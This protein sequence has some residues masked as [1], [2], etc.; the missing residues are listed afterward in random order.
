MNAFKLPAPQRLEAWGNFR[1]SL[2]AMP[3][4]DQI[5]AVAEF[6]QH[7]P[8]DRW[9]L[10]P[11]SPNDWMSPWEMLYEGQYCINCVAVGIEST[12]RYSG[13][14]ESRL[15]LVM[16]KEDDALAS[17]FFVVKIDNKYVLNYSYGQ[18][19]PIEELDASINF[20]YAYRWNG[21]S[22]ARI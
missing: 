18:C 19:V 2:S 4:L 21:K 20:L 5:M 17:E 10:D 16:I 6:W 7:C 8:F 1:D 9:V 22:Y 3:E 14:D 15:E 13:W 11:L 12:L